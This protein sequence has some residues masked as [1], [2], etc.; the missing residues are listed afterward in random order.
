LTDARYPFGHPAIINRMRN[1]AAG[2]GHEDRD[3]TRQ[4]LLLAAV[5]G[6]AAL[7][8]YWAT[9]RS[10]R[11]ILEA[12]H[13]EPCRE[14]QPMSYWIS[15]LDSPFYRVRKNAVTNIGN[16]GVPAC[17]AI[18]ALLR[19][20]QRDHISLRSW[21]INQGLGNMG[22]AGVSAVRPF[23]REPQLRTVAVVTLGEMGS[24]AAGTVSDLLPLLNDRTWWTRV[25]V[26]RALKSMG[27]AARD[28]LPALHSALHNAEPRCRV[29]ILEAIQAIDRDPSDLS[30]MNL[31]L[32]ETPRRP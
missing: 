14:G 8:V 12:I 26:C 25:Q 4:R 1:T 17:E 15:A 22:V 29:A 13:G 16:I 6:C 19:M 20:A 21:A 18:P 32:Q 30:L 9:S 7:Q 23:L 2:I 3:M 24:I 10:S 27:P 28:A 11:A 31:G 5:L